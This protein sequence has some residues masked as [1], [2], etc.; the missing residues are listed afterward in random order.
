[1]K[2]DIRKLSGIVPPLITPLLENSELDVEGLERLIEHVIIGGV[3]GIFILG[4]TGELS[5]LSTE[6]KKSVV[7]ETC[8]IVK[9]RV[10][11]LV[12]ITDT[13][14]LESLKLEKLAK[15]YGADAVVL[16]PPFYYHVEQDELLDYFYDLA[17]KIT[18]PLFLYNILQVINL[19]HIH[20][21]RCFVQFYE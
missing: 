12:G 14:M 21:N 1:M 2:S 19:F 15:E 16:A 20:F 5:R 18:L 7:K 13:S 6:V 4:T 3:S 11:V 9:Q 8:R 10:P 17:S